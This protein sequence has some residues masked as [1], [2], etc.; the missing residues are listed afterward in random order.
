MFYFSDLVSQFCLHRAAS[1][2]GQHLRL[3]PLHPDKKLMWKREMN[4]FLSICDHIVE[5]VPALHD[6]QDGTAV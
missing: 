1:I 2:F 6:L 3:E 5:F 4:C